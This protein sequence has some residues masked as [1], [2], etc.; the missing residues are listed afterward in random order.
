MLDCFGLHRTCILTEHGELDGLLVLAR[1]VLGD[2]RVFARVAARGVGDAEVGVIVDVVDLDALRV[3]Q[4]DVVAPYPRDGWRRLARDV[5][6][7]LVRAARLDG[8]AL[9]HGAVDLRLHCSNTDV[10]IR[11][12]KIRRGEK[13]QHHHTRKS[14]VV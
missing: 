9:Q 4:R 11:F 12:V 3:H 10:K 5:H 2:E 13:E 6:G 1:C 14:V 8:N 7:P